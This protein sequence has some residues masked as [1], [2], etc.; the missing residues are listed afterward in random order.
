MASIMVDFIC[1][2]EPKAN[3][4]SVSLVGLPRVGD[5]VPIWEFGT[6]ADGERVNFR[7]EDAPNV[8]MGNFLVVRVELPVV[9]FGPSYGE[10]NRATSNCPRVHL[11]PERAYETETHKAQRELVEVIVER[12]EEQAVEAEQLDEA[13]YEVH[14]R[15]G[16]DSGADTIN[17]G[18]LDSQVAYLVSKGCKLH[19]ILHFAGEEL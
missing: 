16:G 13:V 17:N 15:C 7:G 3:L 1:K 5:I 12:L 2:E 11:E 9:R 4:N 19:E 14:S 10:G 8:L 18:G 6:W